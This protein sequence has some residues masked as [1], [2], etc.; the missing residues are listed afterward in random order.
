MKHSSSLLTVMTVAML[1]GCV[2]ME[3]EKAEN[4]SP[5]G[6]EFQNDLY[7]GYVDLSSSEFAEGDYKDSDYFARKAMTAGSGDAVQPTMIKA[8]S[9]PS[10]KEGM[11]STSRQRLMAAMAAGAADKAPDDAARAQVMFDCWMQEQEENFQ[12]NDIDSC[13]TKFYEALNMAEKAVA[14]EP[15]AAAPAPPLS[16]AGGTAAG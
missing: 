14:P 15:V 9:L 4:R 2:G 16:C 5:A 12:A 10:D 11:L 7:S 3:L 13:R 1:S 6:S 8:R